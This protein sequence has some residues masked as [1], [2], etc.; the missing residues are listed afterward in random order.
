MLGEPFNYTVNITLKKFFFQNKYSKCYI[1][2]LCNQWALGTSI[3]FSVILISLKYVTV[4]F[5]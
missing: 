5:N 1:L 3:I 2:E 4:I